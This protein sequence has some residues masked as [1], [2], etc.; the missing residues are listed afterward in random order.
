MIKEG[1]WYF[2]KVRWFDDLSGEGIVQA[3]GSRLFFHWSA[4]TD[5]QGWKSYRGGEFVCFTVVKDVTFTQIN[6][7]RILQT[8]ELLA[9][10]R[11]DPLLDAVR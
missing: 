2:G 5:Q 6:Q 7:I 9:C 8:D 1:Q 11:A 3:S 10:L 4:I